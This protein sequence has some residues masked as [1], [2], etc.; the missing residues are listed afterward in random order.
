MSCMLPIFKKINKKIEIKN[1][2][3]C[4]FHVGDIENNF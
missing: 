4:Y 2:E 3:F 1:D